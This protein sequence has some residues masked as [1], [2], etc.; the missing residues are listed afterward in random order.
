MNGPENRLPV[1]AVAY[2]M[3]MKTPTSFGDTPNSGATTGAS[4]DMPVAASEA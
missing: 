3:P 1:V 2:S 4:T